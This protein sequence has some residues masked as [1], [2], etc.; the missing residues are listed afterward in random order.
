MVEGDA[1]NFK[2]TTREDLALAERLIAGGGNGGAT[3]APRVGFGRD[4]HPLVAGRPFV[5]G[6][7]QIEADA[8]PLGHSDGDALCH[9]IADAILGAAALGDIGKMFP[10]DADATRGIS[11]PAILTGIRG[12][13]GDAGLAIA[14]LDATVWTRK[15]KLASHVPA[16]RACIANALGVPVSSVSVKAKSGNGID[17]VGHGEAVEAECVVALVRA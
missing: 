16:M 8:G 2:I 11:G 10:D 12:M 7:V 3:A 13:L 1:M 17:A 15:P 4:K 6:G 5:M 14:H 9:A